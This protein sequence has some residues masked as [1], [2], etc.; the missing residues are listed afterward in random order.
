MKRIIIKKGTIGL[1]FKCDNYTGFL[2]EGS[3]W[4]L[5]STKIV[6]Y[7]LGERFVPPV[8]IDVLLKDKALSQLMDVVEVRDNEVAL[9]FE[10]DIYK[11]VLRSGRYI[12]WKGFRN[13]RFDI[14]KTD[15][16]DPIDDIHA[17]LLTKS[18]LLPM[19]RSF[20]IESY[21]KGLLYVGGE[22]TRELAPGK[23]CF[24]QN[25]TPIMVKKVDLRQQQVE[26][27]G[28][29]I[30]TKDK[31]A[32]RINFFA[33]YRVVDI[34]KCLV[35]TKDYDRQLYILLQLALREYLGSF[36][37]DELLEKKSSISANIIERVGEKAERL[38]VRIVDCG[39]RDII[40]PG[41][42]KEIMN[43]VL[44]AQKKAQANIITRREETASTRSL[45]N[46]AKMM[47]NN[48]MLF[49]LKEMEYVEKIA[50]KINNIT[51]SGG[52]HV[53]QQLKEIF[54]A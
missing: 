1:R 32:L 24:W 13:R 5:P 21:E 45:L 44:V 11:T 30:L 54:S 6:S 33:Q 28:Q 37:L 40:L 46:T 10:D 34:E 51:L 29:E 9:V 53:A 20:F 15:S 43:R 36:G 18:A 25:A 50:E 41:E 16:V 19:V 4:V 42:V 52:G 22:L 31:A 26:V 39:I 12:W 38:G 7:N 35:E 47:E 48:E 17:N 8:D 27:S 14:Y 49:K 2:E 23:Y 3:Y